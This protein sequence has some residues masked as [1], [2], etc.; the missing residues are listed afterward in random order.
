M[1]Q[2]ELIKALIALLDGHL[3]GLRG[4]VQQEPYKQ[5]FFALFSQVHRIGYFEPPSS[6]LLTADSL[7]DILVNRWFADDGQDDEREELLNQLL[8]AW[9]EWR[10]ALEHY[11]LAY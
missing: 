8:S 5:D 11:G 7:R 9:R 1:T 6:P 4:S 3:T 2:E 10:Y